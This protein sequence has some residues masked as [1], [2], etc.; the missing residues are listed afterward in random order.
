MIYF[1]A[2]NLPLGTL[3]GSSIPAFHSRRTESTVGST[4]TAESTSRTGGL[5]ATSLGAVVTLP[6]HVR[7]AVLGRKGV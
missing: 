3:G 1:R 2:E 5:R 7:V 6:A 4:W